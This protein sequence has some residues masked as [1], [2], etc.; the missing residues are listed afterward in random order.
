M[1]LNIV[2][3]AQESR[4]DKRTTLKKLRQVSCATKWSFCYALSNGV[5]KIRSSSYREETEDKSAALFVAVDC[6]SG[7]AFKFLRPFRALVNS[8]R[9]SRT[10][11]VNSTILICFRATPTLFQGVLLRLTTPPSS[12]STCE[13]AIQSPLTRPPVRLR[14]PLFVYRM[15]GTS[16]TTSSTP[17]H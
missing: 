6:L 17:V 5:T 10:R 16:I 2:S 8:N 14:S 3:L 12:R 11:E 13:K 15:S 1:R 7:E 9:K 4:R